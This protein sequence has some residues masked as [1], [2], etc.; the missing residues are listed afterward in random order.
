MSA[1]KN[2]LHDT[3]EAGMRE[4]TPSLFKCKPWASITQNSES[5]TIAANIMVILSRTGDK[6]RDLSWEEYKEER[7]K[8]GSFTE[9][10]KKYFDD[11]IY[12]AK[13]DLDKITGFSDSWKEAYD[14]S[15]QK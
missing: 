9:G 2:E 12:L 14:K 15:L 7:I 8:D 13:G 10:E 3:I 11:L 4:I 6:F 5:E 1:I